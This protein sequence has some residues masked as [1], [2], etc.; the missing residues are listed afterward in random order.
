M[1][2]PHSPKTLG[3]LWLAR[4]LRRFYTLVP[5]HLEDAPVQQFIRYDIG[6]P[7]RA[8][9]DT[10][11]R[12]IWAYWNG[13]QPPWLVQRCLD[14]WAFFN[15]GFSIR[16]LNDGILADYLPQV[17]QELQ[18]LPVAKRSDWIRLE[19]L[20]R[21]GGIWLDASTILTQSL[22]WVLKQQQRTQAEFVG[23]FLDQYTTQPQCPVV[24]N[25][26]MAAPAGSP[27]I[28]DVR[29]EFSLQAM[30]RSNEQ[31]VAYLQDLGVY[32]QLLQNIDMPWYLSQHLA[33]QHVLHSGTHYRLCLAKAE[34]GPYF[35]HALGNWRR[36]P[37]K[38]RLM[39]S[40]SQQVPPLIKLRA[41]DRKRLDLYLERGLYVR[42]SVAQRYLIDLATR[43]PT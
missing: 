22:D 29:R 3:E 10:I 17:P 2:K 40:R 21:Y 7:A 42:G 31:Y 32:G 41:P 13:S 37:L 36:T 28:A 23:Y 15:P 24:E 11:P 34:D 16:L 35:L 4:W 1:A 30:T 39:F 20:H 33:I 38:L 19:L 12:T 9:A 27:F 8:H 6:G 43:P 26:F 5:R 14:S 18:A 25:W